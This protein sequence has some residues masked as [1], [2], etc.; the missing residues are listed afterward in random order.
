MSAIQGHRSPTGVWISDD[1]RSNL[2]IDRY[3]PVFADMRGGKIEQLRS[4]NSEDAIT[5]NVFRSLR[6]IAP[7]A[8]LP[9]LWSRSFNAPV[10]EDLNAEI[11][12]WKRVPPPPDLLADADEGPSEIDVMIE[13]AS[14]VWFIEAKYHSDISMKTAKRPTRDQ[15]LRNI[16]VGSYYAGT[17]DFYFSLLITSE[18][19]SPRGVE[20]LEKYSD[21]NVVREHL[22][23]RT[24]GITNLRAVGKLLW[25]QLADVLDVLADSK[26]ATAHQ[27]ER[28]Y[29]S[30][31]AEWL[32]L[33]VQEQL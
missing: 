5:W 30:R 27:D 32:K 7:E 11:T 12:L 18:R 14:W 9:L 1:F 28:A 2:I 23:H 19:T 31:A 15:V 25:S 16:D 4:V 33:R 6:Q 22:V 26:Y 13:A 17:R 8:W 10:P 24:D 29:A 20:K 3:D 21:F